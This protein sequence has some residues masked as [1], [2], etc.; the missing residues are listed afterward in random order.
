MTFSFFVQASPFSLVGIFC[1]SDGVMMMVGRVRLQPFNLLL[2]RKGLMGARLPVSAGW[3][4]T[5]GGSP[6]A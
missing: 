2:G 4:V 6:E 5:T 3:V 1:Y